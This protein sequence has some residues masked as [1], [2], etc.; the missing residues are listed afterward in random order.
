[1]T[2]DETRQIPEENKDH[3]KTDRCLGYGQKG[4]DKKIGETLKTGL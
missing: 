1:M 2:G 4:S 3:Q